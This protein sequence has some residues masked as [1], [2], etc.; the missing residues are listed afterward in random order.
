MN[1]R[2][3]LTLLEVLAALVLLT[4]VASTTLSLMRSATRSLEAKQ[5]DVDAVALGELADRFLARPAEF[6]LDGSVESG[7]LAWPDAP[8][9]E[10]ASFRLLRPQDAAA[11]HHGWLEVSAGGTR[12]FRWIRALPEPEVAR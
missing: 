12:V 7:L 2:S 8:G 4:I 9:R 1:A 3:G 11:T 5:S 6:G 10:P